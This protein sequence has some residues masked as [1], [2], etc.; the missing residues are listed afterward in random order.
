LRRSAPLHGQDGTHRSES[1]LADGQAVVTFQ[2]RETFLDLEWVHSVQSG[3]D[4]FPQD[5]FRESAV[6]LTSSAGIHGD[7]SA[8]RLRATSSRCRDGSTSTSPTSSAAS[9]PSPTGTRL[10]PSPKSGPV[11]SVSARSVEGSSIGSRRWDSTSSASGASQRRSRA[12]TPSTDRLHEA[13]SDARFVVLAV[14]LTDATEGLIDA[15]VFDAMP[16][17]AYLVNVARGGVVDQ[18]ALVE[19]LRADD[20]AGA[21]LDVF[22]TEPLPDPRRSGSWT[23]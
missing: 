22:E 4:R 21:A 15:D 3:V 19:A 14:P 6:V 5:R 23:T 2:H 20:V 12:L 7:A 1:S 13:V 9:G 10:G 11:S 17:D 8:R 16:D 18:S